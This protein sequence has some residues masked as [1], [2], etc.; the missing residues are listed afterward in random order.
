MDEISDSASK[1]ALCD[2]LN[3]FKS[4]KQF[5]GY[6]CMYFFKR[7]KQL[8]YS[9]MNLLI[10]EDLI[11]DYWHKDGLQ[12]LKLNKIK[13]FLVEPK[14]QNN[15]YPTR[16]ISSRQVSKKAIVEVEPK[17]QEFQVHNGVKVFGLKG[18][19]VSELQ[20]SSKF[21]GVARVSPG[22]TRSDA[23]AR[24]CHLDVLAGL[25]KCSLEIDLD[26]VSAG[27]FYKT[28]LSESLVSSAMWKNLKQAALN[29]KAQKKGCMNILIWNNA[30]GFTES[31][32]TLLDASKSFDYLAYY[33][34]E[35]DE[36]VLRQRL[37]FV[38]GDTLKQ[39]LL[40]Y[41]QVFPL[42]W[43]P[44][45]GA[46]LNVD[47]FVRN[48][49]QIAGIDTKSFHNVMMF[50]GQIIDQNANI[51]RRDQSRGRQVWR[52]LVSNL[53]DDSDDKDDEFH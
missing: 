27:F 15:S 43:S 3:E 12:E 11:R 48:C 21:F 25:M 4:A 7:L 22:T 38:D 45:L 47:R 5:Y 34:W 40:Q 19:S 52:S 53:P 1:T 51:R 42:D 46:F 31:L 23:D 33:D 36:Q 13:D 41:T 37:H 14:M 2:I 32:D 44:I 35:L 18:L 16:Q 24:Q 49:K 17:I 6:S 29:S 9:N 30:A 26:Q 10:I 20:K 28:K 50:L 39:F 8:G